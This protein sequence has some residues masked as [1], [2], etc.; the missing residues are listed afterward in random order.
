MP[1]YPFI[2][3]EHGVKEVSMSMSDIKGVKEH[4]CPECGQMMK[5]KFIPHK[6]NMK[7]PLAGRGLEVY[8][9]SQDAEDQLFDSIT[10]EL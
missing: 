2:C 9:N 1:F 10:E 5:R 8:T 6:I 7:Q 3:Q 4:P